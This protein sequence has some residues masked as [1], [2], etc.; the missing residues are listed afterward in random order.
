MPFIEHEL[1]NKF[2]EL[3]LHKWN[4][5]VNITRRAHDS[6][7]IVSDDI[8]NFIMILQL[9]GDFSSVAELAKYPHNSEVRERAPEVLELGAWLAPL[10]NLNSPSW[11]R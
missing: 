2:I 4:Y 1:H 8:I 5:G 11:D 3:Q 6:N 7:K 10:L 9:I